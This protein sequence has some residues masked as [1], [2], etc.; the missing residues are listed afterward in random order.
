MEVPLETTPGYLVLK[1]WKELERRMGYRW[2]ADS[3]GV[4]VGGGFRWGTGGRETH[5]GCRWAEIPMGCRWVW[6]SDGG[7]CKWGK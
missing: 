6:D 4:K 7:G 3:D 2:E 1:E 5:I